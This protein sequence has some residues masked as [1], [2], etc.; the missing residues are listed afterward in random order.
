MN[1]SFNGGFR[2]HFIECFVSNVGPLLCSIQITHFLLSR[3]HSCPIRKEDSTNVFSTFCR[4][5][6]LG[7]PHY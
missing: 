5:E 4:T 1:L 6:K 2:H 3:T 7:D